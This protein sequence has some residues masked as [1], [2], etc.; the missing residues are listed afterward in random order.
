[1]RK[2]PSKLLLLGFVPLMV[3]VSGQA[4]LSLRAQ[5]TL[6]HDAQADRARSLADMLVEVAGPNVV[7]NDAWAADVSLGYARRQPD[8]VFAAIALPDGKPF[9]WQGAGDDSGANLKAIP[10]APEPYVKVEGG[11]LVASSP[12]KPNGKL[13]GAVV[14]G[15]SRK[16][17]SE[18][19][20][21]D[22]RRVVLLS[23]AGAV[24][25][26][27]L[28]WRYETDRKRA[29]A[30]LQTAM[31]G[32]EKANVAKSEFLANM[33]HEIRT[34]M[35]AI[36][37]YADLLLDP[38]ASAS[39]TVNHVQTIRRNGEHLLSIINDVLDLSKIEAGAMR[40]ELIA[41][42]PA[43]IAVD[44]AS[45]L[46]VRA[47][48]KKLRLD[49]VFETAIPDTIQSD[50]TRLR[51]IVMNLVSNA[52]K[53]TARGEVRIAVRCDLLA[54]RIAFEVADTGVGLTTEQIA[55]LFKPFSQADTSTTRRFGGTGLGLAI[56]QRL[57][58]MMG[59]QV[60]VQSLPGRG[61]AF[62]VTV[63]TGS[64][65]GV[66][67]VTDLSEAVVPAVAQTPVLAAAPALEANVLLAEDGYDNR[68]LIEAH[69]RKAGARIETAENGRIAVE[70]AL[71]GHFDVIL[72]DMQMPELDGYGA[73][74][75]LRG[76][77][78]TGPILALT[79]HA[80]AGDR[81]KCLG[82]GCDDYLTKPIDRSRLYA[83]VA[84]WSAKSRQLR[85]P[86]AVTAA[87]TAAAND[88]P[89]VST[90]AADEEMAGILAGFV[91]QL[92]VRAAELSA[93]L[94]AADLARVARIAHQLK[95]AA[96][97][98]GFAPI[99]DAAAA[100]EAATLAGDPPLINARAD[101]LAAL[102]RLAIAA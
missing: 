58:T 99:T 3:A 33:S 79:A 64:L 26:A 91:A 4:L 101:R 8:F 35:T 16:K 55:R 84:S 61:S 48:E 59:G 49:V 28:A 9:A 65:A 80:M 38:C 63:T 46:R 11:I 43:Q 95:G 78:Y 12:I 17:I 5:H 68:V 10:A 29:F 53:F 23:A 102:C 54:E 67:L 40:T 25:A 6:L 15:L 37:G 36:T 20:A 45:L 83:A 69:L 98:Y 57:A 52:I 30:E 75:L 41:C 96:A 13:L 71:A 42:S 21:A 94:A 24:L 85:P 22:T 97:G 62:T 87:V 73:T 66:H 90:F 88:G 89:L 60:E 39:D 47:V 77:G 76:K 56:S 72:M 32:I 44:V 14:L 86:A 18:A 74:A 81:E 34:P 7:F 19:A 31:N 1:M 100:L 92:P 82:A 51:Q 50:P 70:K 93:A 27:L 2:Q